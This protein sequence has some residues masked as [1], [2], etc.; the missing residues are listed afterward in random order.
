MLDQSPDPTLPRTGL[1]LGRLLLAVLTSVAAFAAPVEVLA[2]PERPANTRYEPKVWATCDGMKQLAA[3][4]GADVLFGGLA[5]KLCNGQP[6]DRLLY[7]NKKALGNM[8]SAYSRAHQDSPQGAQAARNLQAWQLELDRQH[9]ELFGLVA[10]KVAGKPI[11]PFTAIAAAL[12]EPKRQERVDAFIMNMEPYLTPENMLP[13]TRV[14]L[15][16]YGGAADAKPANRP[17]LLLTCAD[18]AQFLTEMPLQIGE[19][20]EPLYVSC[21]TEPNLPLEFDVAVLEGQL[22]KAGLDDAAL[23]HR[24]KLIGESRLAEAG[25]LHAREQLAK[26][27]RLEQEALLQRMKN[28][29][30]AARQ[31]R[32]AE[33]D[34]ERERIAQARREQ[35]AEEKRWASLTSAQQAQELKQ[36]AEMERRQTLAW[37]VNALRF[38]ESAA[39]SM[40]GTRMV[41]ISNQM[42][43]RG[44][45]QIP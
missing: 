31:R 32:Q 9:R 23:L 29:D 39:S 2:A 18:M 21:Y 11:V 7:L 27:K 13:V 35:D 15:R 6:D 4:P 14:A 43:Y 30:A 26:A 34:E 19:N 10:G 45:P 37:C 36:R 12:N 8:F 5:Q 38:Y 44:C 33:V 22:R 42:R 16:N 40:E 17:V 25:Q 28:E 3:R 1:G 24:I 20:A 41:S